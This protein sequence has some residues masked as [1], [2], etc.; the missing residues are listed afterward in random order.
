ME[1]SDTTAQPT[2]T[3]KFFSRIRNSLSLNRSLEP[4]SPDVVLNNNENQT[5]I[6][7]T[8][9]N[10]RIRV[11]MLQLAVLI[12]MPSPHNNAP[13]KNPILEKLDLD[14]DDDEKESNDVLPE[15]VFGVTRVNYRQ[16][17]SS[18]LPPEPRPT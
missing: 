9:P 2:R 4:E 7:S 8:T 14:A 12:T 5:P 10:Y 6:P 17:S 16:P 1:V 3:S 18:T 11:E 15:M 13:R